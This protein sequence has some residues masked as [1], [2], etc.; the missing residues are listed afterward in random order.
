MGKKDGSRLEAL[1]DAAGALD[2]VGVFSS[3]VVPVG[4][5]LTGRS[6]WSV[7]LVITPVCV[8][9][10][11]RVVVAPAIVVVEMIWSWLSSSES[12]GMGRRVAFEGSIASPQSLRC[13]SMNV[14]LNS[15][16]IVSLT[17]MVQVPIPD[18]P[19]LSVSH[20]KGWYLELLTSEQ[21]T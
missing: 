21:R 11:A 1:V 12:L 2:E 19:L 10:G 15:F 18:S 16:T 6:G 17:T 5:A 14:P 7:G 3:S 9:M 8:L 20:G 13:Q 4:F